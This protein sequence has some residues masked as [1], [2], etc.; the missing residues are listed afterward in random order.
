MS[1][2]G[3]NLMDKDEDGIKG[4]YLRNERKNKEAWILSEIEHSHSFP[5][6]IIGLLCTALALGICW[7]RISLGSHSW[8]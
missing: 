6:V 2:A 4:E 5:D 7:S 3:N 8:N 1:E